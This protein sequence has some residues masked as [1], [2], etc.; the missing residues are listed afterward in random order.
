MM[1]A[2]WRLRREDS[3]I[4]KGAPIGFTSAAILLLALSAGPASAADVVL[5]DLG[6]EQGPTS[7]KIP[8][9]EFRG[10]SLTKEQ[11]QAIL[12]PT[13]PEPVATRI[14]RLQ[15][16]S[17]VVP[18]MRVEASAPQRSVTTYKN[19]VLTK[20]GGGRIETGVADGGTVE[21]TM[22]EGST[23]G[24]MG[25]MSLQGMDLG[26]ALALM[27]PS[28]GAASMPLKPVYQAF[29]LDGFS[30]TDAKGI[31]VRI[32]RIGGT[33]FSARPTKEGWT[34]LALAMSPPK[35]QKAETAEDRK[36]RFVALGEL[37]DSFRIGS[38]QASDIALAEG[39]Q[40]RGRLGSF[41]FTGA[42][43]ARDAGFR[44][45][46]LDVPTPDGGR[47]RLAAFEMAGI[48]MKPMIDGLQNL[49]DGDPTN[50]SP[51]EMRKLIPLI[52]LVKL[53][54]I[55][56]DIAGPPGSPA[57]P[58]PAPAVSPGPDRRVLPA[59]SPKSHEG[60]PAVAGSSPAAPSPAVPSPS[61][62]ARGT[63]RISVG[64]IEIASAKPVEGIPTDIRIG[65]KNVAFP[66]MVE[67]GNDAMM[68]LAGLGYDKIDT[69]FSANVGWNESGQEV[70]IREISLD[71]AGM[72]SAVIRGIVGNVSRGVFAPEKTAAMMSLLG[73]TAKSLEIAVE[74]KGL[75]NRVLGRQ[76]QTQKRGVED[77][78]KEYA[79]AA[80]IGIPAILGNSPN[81]KALA[82]AIAK[83]IAK[84]NRLVLTAK[85]KSAA[86][87][88]FADYM[89]GSDPAS[90][91]NALDV[92][93]V[94]E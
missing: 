59:E 48:S 49:S 19:L 30:I 52:G 4:T 68:Q 9:A 21:T 92:T 81:A 2:A 31:T 51:A 7:Y 6:F 57:A 36:R 79:N 65:V 86:G 35:D 13:G 45:D 34:S 58:A 80:Q 91:L 1:R 16:D 3:A 20:V 18:E 5:T 55:D 93:A 56:V 64:S 17:I 27:A 72:G 37:F 24:T 63:S 26:L 82:A 87:Y 67:T 32:G 66:V 89:G 44:F 15:A 47:V 62:P 74:D 53:T 61:A 90:V 29:S 78:R 40:E 14:A 77:V 83:F 50:L 39:G 43:G 70:V 12:S 33:E 84:P 42:E 60:D 88:G 11:L 54:G 94:A 22:P 85:A 38:M 25:R 73:A 8:R 76:A 10:T 41:T 23:R 71:S 28:P 75:F 46:S 69:S